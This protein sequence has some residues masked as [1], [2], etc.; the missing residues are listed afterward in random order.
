MAR[1]L[2]VICREVV[3]WGSQVLLP[4]TS[5]FSSTGTLQHSP[6]GW[7][8]ALPCGCP[9]PAHPVPR[10]TPRVPTQLPH[11]L[12]DDWLYRTLM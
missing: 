2:G 5:P 1:P 9:I 4:P 7:Y 8:A 3:D 11:T 12:W 10:S 6:Q